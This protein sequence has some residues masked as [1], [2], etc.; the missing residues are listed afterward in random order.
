[1]ACSDAPC[2]KLQGH[3]SLI[4]ASP[5]AVKQSPAIVA[6]GNTRHHPV[7]IDHLYMGRD[8]AN[9]VFSAITFDFI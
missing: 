9:L 5:I 3:R 2:D 8:Y 6:T 7:E 1:M 4:Y